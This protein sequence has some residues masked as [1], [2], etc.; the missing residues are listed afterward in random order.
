M[1]LA[2]E[3]ENRKIEDARQEAK[4]AENLAVKTETVR[5][6]LQMGLTFRRAAKLAGDSV[7][8]V[9][10]IQQQLGPN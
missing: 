5:N 1:Q 9:K 10:N 3:N 2:I 6:A 4:E 8:F 7:E